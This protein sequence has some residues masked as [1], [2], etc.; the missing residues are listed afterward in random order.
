MKALTCT[1]C[2]GTINKEKMRCEYCG[3]KYTAEWELPHPVIRMEPAGVQV[4]RTKTVIDRKMMHRD[5]AAVGR[6]VMEDMAR[7]IAQIIMP[8]VEIIQRDDQAYRWTEI[9][10]RV[11]VLEKEFR[12]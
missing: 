7:Q 1:Q 5:A 6:L 2:G 9:E 12:F 10:G 3:T 4:L 8:M 11:R